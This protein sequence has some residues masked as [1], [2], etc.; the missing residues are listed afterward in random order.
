MLEQSELGTVPVSAVLFWRDRIFNEGEKLLGRGPW[1]LLLLSRSWVS[2]E[3]DETVDGMVPVREVEDR[4]S[5][6]RE[7]WSAELDDRDESGLVSCCELTT[8]GEKLKNG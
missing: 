7:T 6:W 2:A 1:R 3:K 5:S 8:L 4:S